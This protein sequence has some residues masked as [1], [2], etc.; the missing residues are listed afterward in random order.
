M[1]T[2]EDI[3]AFSDS[4][5]YWTEPEAHYATPMQ[6]VKYFKEFTGQ[7]GTPELYEGLIDEEYDE[8]NFELNLQSSEFSKHYAQKSNPEAELKELADLVY[9][10]Y[11][12]AL[13]RGWNLDEALYR[14]HVNNILR[15]KQPDGTVKRREDGKILKVDNPPKVRLE[16]LV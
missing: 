7:E 16:D 13:S 1:I 5:A 12:Y 2:H 15:V 11:G 6:M 10:I 8:W 14:V 4:Y 3:E 9:V